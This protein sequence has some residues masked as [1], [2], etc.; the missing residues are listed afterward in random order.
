MVITILAF[1]RVGGSEHLWVNGLYDSF[2]ILLLFPLIVYLGASG[3]VAGKYSSKI[4]RFLGNVSYPL[5]ITHYPII[6]IFT[7]WVADNH[8]PLNKAWPVGIVVLV[9]AILLSYACLKVY[10]IPVRTWL[11]KRFISKKK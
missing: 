7:A 4:S 2:A 11:A 9:T 8:V 5:Y 10:D 1:P 6:Y 3:K